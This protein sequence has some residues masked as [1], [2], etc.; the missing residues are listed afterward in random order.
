MYSYPLLCMLRLLYACVLIFVL[1]CFQNQ[2][3]KGDQ[4]PVIRP[5]MRRF[6][7]MKGDPGSPGMKGD[8]G[9]SIIGP[10]GEH[11]V[12]GLPGR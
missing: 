10:K 8:R 9:F 4:G 2:G 3:E 6:I 12:R 1:I 7:L 11:G 5:K